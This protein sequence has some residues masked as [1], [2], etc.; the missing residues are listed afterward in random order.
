MTTI[1]LAR[2]GETD[3]NRDGIWQGWADP[4]LNDTGRA[5]AREL[6]EQLRTTP[7]DAV[8]SS[9]LRR[10]HETALIVA[11]PHEV[12]IVADPG[13]REIDI[14]P[15]SGL[16]RAEIE[17]RFPDGKR[18]GGETREQHA[19]RVLEAVE[20]IAREHPGERILLVTHGGTMR[21][22]HGHVSDDP[23]HPVHN[24]SVLEL[25]F[26]D[27]RLATPAPRKRDADAD[28]IG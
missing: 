8:Y 24:C 14:G 15:W 27:D 11:E 13:L 7:F 6:A 19:T 23:V 1:L 10:A 18:P 26:R 4:P 9:D 20:R 16:T 3:W 12:P 22:L 5:Q 17:E 21:A 25:H 28:P 2:H